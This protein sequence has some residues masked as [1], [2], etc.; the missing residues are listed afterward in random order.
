MPFWLSFVYCIGAFSI[1][2]GGFL[3][4]MGLIDY[5]G[6]YVIH[7]SSGTSGVVGSWLI[8]P[9]LPKDRT[10][11]PN[12]IILVVIGAGLLWT[13]WNG[14]SGGHPYTAS[15]GAA[16]ALLNTNV[17]AATSILVWIS[18]D[19][20][21]Y[22]K[23]SIIGAV[24]GMITGL[25]A[26]APGAGVVAAWSAVTIG[27]I[28]GFTI[29]LILSQKFRFFSFVDDTLDIFYTHGVASALGGFLTGIF[30]TGAGCVAFSCNDAGGAIAGNGRQV[31]VQIVGILF[32]VGWNVVWT[33]IL[34]L[35]VRF[36]VPLRMIEEQLVVGDEMIHGES[37][38]ISAE[39][40]EMSIG[41]FRNGD[42]LQQHA[43]PA[44]TQ[45]VA[46]QLP[47]A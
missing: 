45:R 44:Y 47:Q 38:C 2:G 37:A 35:L 27:V 42:Q 12:S 24:E 5:A 33:A 17:C 14:F 30:A 28:S 36:V 15:A 39:C 32:V 1:W 7:L 22:K 18:C 23:P 34:L 8:G 10:H 25:V 13:G 40:L 16:V 43:G 19:A 46:G 31:W 4:K 26:I 20:V 9:R 11:V 6:G 29:W 41:R 3:S 21:Y